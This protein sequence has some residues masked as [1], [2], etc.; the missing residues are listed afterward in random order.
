MLG[1]SVLAAGFIS[2]LGCFTKRYRDRLVGEWKEF[3]F[4]NS[5]KYSEDFSVQRVMGDPVLI[6]TWQ[7]KGLPG[8]ELSIDNGIISTAAKRWPLI[9]DPQSQGNKWIKNMEKENN[10]M[11]IKL[12]N[13]KFLQICD[14][15]IRLGYPVLLENIH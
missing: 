10:L 1:N 15:S 7:M 2:Y 5:M 3:L 11:V 14:T 4:K 9:I 8:D 12:T 6:R 13:P